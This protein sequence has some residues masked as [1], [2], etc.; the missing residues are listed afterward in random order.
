MAERLSPKQQTLVRFQQTSQSTAVFRGGCFILHST[1]I[2]KVACHGK[3]RAGALFLSIITIACDKV[4]A[5]SF[6]RRILWDACHRK[7]RASPIFNRDRSFALCPAFLRAHHKT[8]M[9][10]RCSF[11][12]DNIIAIRNDSIHTVKTQTA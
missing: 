12:N 9:H 8:H 3:L 1:N 5:L 4:R 7:V 2:L 11:C 6:P 10:Q